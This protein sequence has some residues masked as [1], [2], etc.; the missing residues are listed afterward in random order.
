MILPLPLV[1]ANLIVVISCIYVTQ[2]IMPLSKASY[3]KYLYYSARAYLSL[4]AVYHLIQIILPVPLDLS[5]SLN[6]VGLAIL[7][8]E[9]HTVRGNTQTGSK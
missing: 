4:V 7:F 5:S 8:H 3:N 9:I 2:E 1:I 6:A